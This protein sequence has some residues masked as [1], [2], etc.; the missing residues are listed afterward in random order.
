[1]NDFLA[2]HANTGMEDTYACRQVKSLCLLFR[3]TRLAYSLVS[4]SQDGLTRY[5]RLFDMSPTIYKPELT[6]IALRSIK[7]YLASLPKDPAGEVGPW[8]SSSLCE[9]YQ[10]LYSFVRLHSD[11]MPS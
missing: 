2:G 1:M 10:I 7:A 3:V 6:T 8:A 5:G 9:V 4:G 11:D